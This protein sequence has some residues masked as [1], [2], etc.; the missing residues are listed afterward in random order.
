MIKKQRLG[1]YFSHDFINI[2]EETNGKLSNFFKV[3][4]IFLKD[5]RSMTNQ[6]VA[7]EAKFINPIKEELK[8]NNV[9]TRDTVLTLPGEDLVV[10]FFDIPLVIKSEIA[11]TI[12]F[13]VK[14]YIPFR[15]EEITF[16]FQAK[17][18]K[19]AKKIS[20]LFIG[21]KKEIIDRYISLL[22]QVGLNII[23]VEPAFLSLLRALKLSN[24]EAKLPFAVLDVDAQA[25]IGEITVI[26]N[27]YPRFSR[28]LD[29]RVSA[30]D[31]Q[32]DSAGY[33][34]NKLVNEVRISL[35]YCRRQFMSETIYTSRIFFL[36]GA[37][38]A[39][40]SETLN[41]ELDVPTAVFDI[42]T[43]LGLADKG[44]DLG[45][46][47]AY[48]ASMLDT[49]S[50]PLKINLFNKISAAAAT[51]EDAKIESLLKKIDLQ[52]DK[53]YL[54][55][56][57]LVT[58]GVI[59]AVYFFGLIRLNNYS[60]KLNDLKKARE[61][62]TLLAKISS[63]SYDELEGLKDEYDKKLIA[64]E[65]LKK[66]RVYFTHKFSLLAAVRQKGMW[67]TSLIFNDNIK[68]MDFEGLVYL[69]DEKE[70]FYAVNR[71][72]S[73]LKQAKEFSNF[74][75]ISLVSLSRGKHGEKNYYITNFSI[76]CR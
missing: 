14:K 17:I 25:E 76:S 34:L 29:L 11:S 20:V 41:K 3:P 57:A 71:F 68:T 73:E 51:K 40:W 66:G 23:A 16:D 39:A 44:L 2:A 30:D 9:A 67:L 10:R 60:N 61:N 55:I 69:G 52:I 49:A 5:I 46:V 47:R 58:I 27:F 21:V 12:S 64:L 35:D 42:Q 26:E 59:S 50:L 6:T 1:I 70:E 22:E 54:F 37:Q 32:A 56:I 19:K 38:A 74:K 75:D 45:L 8:N 63:L 15:I 31:K 24:M 65:N 53:G 36:D 18:D 48:G 72:L 13:E 33:A 7:Q 62:T 28:E 4:G 43:G